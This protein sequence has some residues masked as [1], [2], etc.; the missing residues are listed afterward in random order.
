MVFQFIVMLKTITKSTGVMNEFC[1]QA[2]RVVRCQLISEYG[3]LSQGAVEHT[4]YCES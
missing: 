4:V 2:N 3:Y 1:Q